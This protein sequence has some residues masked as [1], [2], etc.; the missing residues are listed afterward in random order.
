[1]S[2]KQTEARLRYENNEDPKFTGSLRDEMSRLGRNVNTNFRKINELIKNYVK[3]H[4]P[5]GFKFTRGIFTQAEKITEIELIEMKRRE[6][7]LNPN[8]HAN[9]E[10]LCSMRQMLEN[11]LLW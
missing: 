3:A 5:R 10:D 6:D 8:R 1:V 7:S 11:P 2:Q 9:A 4:L